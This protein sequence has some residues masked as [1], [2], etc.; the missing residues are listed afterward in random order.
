MGGPGLTGLGRRRGLETDVAGHIYW[1]YQ[2]NS[3]TLLPDIDNAYI[4]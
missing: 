2:K 1:N 4:C 3:F